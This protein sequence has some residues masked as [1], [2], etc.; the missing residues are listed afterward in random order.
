[1]IIPWIDLGIVFVI[2]LYFYAGW[3]LIIPLG[4]YYGLTKDRSWWLDTIYILSA[5]VAMVLWLPILIIG[6]VAIGNKV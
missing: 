1:M 4:W 2:L 6:L 3:N 5:I